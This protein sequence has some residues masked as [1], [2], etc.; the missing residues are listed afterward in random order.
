MSVLI[1][2]YRHFFETDTARMTKLEK[3]LEYVGRTGFV[4]PHDLVPLGVP[5][6]YLWRL[7]R[8][9]LLERIGRGLYSVPG[10]K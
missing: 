4:R 6:D 8:R 3:V 2:N 5:Q 9:G 10:P 1:G 7:H